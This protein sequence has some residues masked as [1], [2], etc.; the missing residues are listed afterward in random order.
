MKGLFL[1]DVVGQ[2][3]REAV[4]AYLPEIKEKLAPDVIVANVENAAHG[5]GLTPKMFDFFKRQG[6]HVMTMGNHTFDKKEVLPLLE[7]K[8]ELIRPLNYPKGTLGKGFYL[9]TLDDGR[10]IGVVQ[11]MG[12]VFMREIASPFQAIQSFLSEHILGKDFSALIVDFH[13]EATSEKVAL[14]HFC[15]GKVSLVAGT[16]THIPTADAQRL[17]LGTGYI[18]D[19]G[20]C[21]DYNSIIGMQVQTVMPRFTG[22]PRPAMAPAETEKTLC[23]V[24]FETDDAT[25]LCLSIRPIRLGTRLIKAL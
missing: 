21:G 3:G 17:P 18:T 4:A 2:A 15:D 5:F 11:L 20:M 10:K 7:N 24:F 8:Q 23:G 9:H 6:V 16:H 25:G 22:K 13:A 1:G 12:Q 14:G 19:V